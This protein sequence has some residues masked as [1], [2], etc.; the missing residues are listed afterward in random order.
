MVYYSTFLITELFTTYTISFFCVFF[1]TFY[2]CYVL[3]YPVSGLLGMRGPNAHQLSATQSGDIAR[4]PA[5]AEAG[6]VIKVMT[7]RLTPMSS[8]RCARCRTV[9]HLQVSTM[10]A[11]E[12]SSLPDPRLVPLSLSALLFRTSDFIGYSAV[13]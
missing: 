5:R 10:A 2:K 12:R 4:V 7:E 13:M 9:R 1:P 3:Q 8:T 11:A 6:T